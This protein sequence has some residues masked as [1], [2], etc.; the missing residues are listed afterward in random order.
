MT[1]KLALAAAL[2]AAFASAAFA[3]TSDQREYLANSGRWI[4]QTDGGAFASMRARMAAPQKI[5]WDA[6]KARFDR[7][8]VVH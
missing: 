1:T 2:L 3:E 7:T 8:S 4:A 5:N 6:E